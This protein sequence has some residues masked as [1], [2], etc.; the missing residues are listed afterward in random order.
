M[1]PKQFTE[2]LH[3][4]IPLTAALGVHVVSC[5]PDSLRVAAPLTLNRNHHGTAFGGSLATLAIIGGW[6]LLH[7]ALTAEGIDTRLVVQHTE[8]DFLEPVAADFAAETRLPPAEEW[9]RFVKM[10][11]KF[12]RGRITVETDLYAG[13]RKVVTQRGTFAASEV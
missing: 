8:C 13:D 2:Y 7:H 10:L 1:N 4:N 3:H 9:T 11:R 5:M 12:R 6:S